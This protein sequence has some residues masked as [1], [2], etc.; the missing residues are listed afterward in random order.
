VSD[1]RNEVK[2]EKFKKNW[3]KVEVC[4]DFVSMVCSLI[5]MIAGLVFVFQ[6][7]Y[8]SSA[9]CFLMAFISTWSNDKKY[10]VDPLIKRVNKLLDNANQIDIYKESE[11]E[12]EEG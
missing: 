12:S 10:S 2:M 4:L 7:K 11:E 3:K 8:D 6:R 9:C 1:K 5:L